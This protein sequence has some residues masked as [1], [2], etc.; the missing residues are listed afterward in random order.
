MV[1]GSEDKTIRMWDAGSGQILLELKGHIRPVLS[2]GFSPDGTRIASG[3]GKYNAAL[4]EIRIWDAK[5]GQSSLELN[6]HTQAVNSVCFSPDGT[7]IA[8]GSSDKTIRIWDAK[9]GQQLSTQKAWPEWAKARSNPGA[10]SPDGK[11]IYL[12][13]P[14]GRIL[15]VPLEIS[16]D[17]L[18]FRKAMSRPDPIWH[19]QQRESARQNQQFFAASVQNYLLHQA[20]AEEH[21]DYNRFDQAFLWSV[22]AQFV[23]PKPPVIHWPELLPPPKPRS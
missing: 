5:T 10:I 18:T 16:E 14:D 2:L 23:K 17:E 15:R 11:F 12:G 7:R 20:I 4:G 1:S 13:Q 21:F 6:G 3:S 8:S 19:R 9:T 22:V